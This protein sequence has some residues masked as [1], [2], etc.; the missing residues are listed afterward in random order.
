MK[1]DDIPNNIKNTPGLGRNM[2]IWGGVGTVAA[3]VLP[4]VAW[5]FGL[6]AGAV[7]AYVKGT[8]RT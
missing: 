3:A 4:F 2:A 5:P 1:F 7:Y 8:K 6:A